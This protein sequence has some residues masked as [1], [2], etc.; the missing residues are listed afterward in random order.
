[1]PPAAPYQPFLSWSP[2][3]DYS[4]SLSL[5]AF[6][7]SSRD[8]KSNAHTGSESTLWTETCLHP[9]ELWF[10]RSPHRLG[11]HK[12]FWSA[13]NSPQDMANPHYLPS[14]HPSSTPILILREGPTA[15]MPV[16]CKKSTS[17]CRQNGNLLIHL[18]I[19]KVDFSFEFRPGVSYYPAFH[20][21]DNKTQA[22]SSRTLATI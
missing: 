15:S 8:Q 4:H 10:I 6:C 22:C 16:I 3:I 21:N 11:R 1:M 17:L 14:I 19:K 5:A 9:H 2:G 7:M 20:N 13:R 18:S 12:T